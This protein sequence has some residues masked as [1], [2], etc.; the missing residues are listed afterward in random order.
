MNESA[1][2]KGRRIRANRKM[3][4]ADIQAAIDI[5]GEWEVKRPGT[6]LNWANVEKLTGFSRPSLAAKVNIQEAFDAA[7]TRQRDSGKPFRNRL[8][9]LTAELRRLKGENE[10]LQAAEDEWQTM[11][12]RAIHNADE[13]GID[14]NILFAPITSSGRRHTGETSAT[15]RGAR[16]SF[17]AETAASRTVAKRRKRKIL[18]EDENPK[19][20]ENA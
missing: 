11:W 14:P 12:Q 2:K 20:D 17:R 7:K 13:L 19:K 15:L 3:T 5:L 4:A 8:D 18:Q 10:R 1:R 16:A 6:P 9:S